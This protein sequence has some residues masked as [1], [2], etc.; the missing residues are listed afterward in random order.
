MES[1]S[2]LP[3]RQFNPSSIPW[4]AFSD[5][6]FGLENWV[7]MINDLAGPLAGPLAARYE[8]WSGAFYTV[9]EEVPRIRYCLE[10]EAVPEEIAAAIEVLINE[11]APV[12]T[13]SYDEGETSHREASA[14]AVVALP[15]VATQL[16]RVLRL[17]SSAEKLDGA[18]A[19][20]NV[21][22]GDEVEQ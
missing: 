16:A 15:G 4:T 22:R 5:L 14:A 7:G 9:F 6:R 18:M 10:T 17:L 13:L 19:L 20:P 1:T 8:D 12:L 21:P 3:A 2:N 11:A